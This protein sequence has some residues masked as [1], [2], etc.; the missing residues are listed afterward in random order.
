MMMMAAVMTVMV[1]MMMAMMVVMMV[2]V[3]MMMMRCPSRRGFRPVFIIES[4]IFEARQKK[5]K[6]KGSVGS[7]SRSLKRPR[8]KTTV[9][10]LTVSIT[11]NVYRFY[12]LPFT[13]CYRLL[14]FA[15]ICYRVLPFSLGGLPLG[16]PTMGF[17]PIK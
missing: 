3:M 13:V 10:T 7:L 15:N 11:F 6:V 17:A 1:M 9:A 8:P 12:R 5:V 4:T 2:V 16:P 14:P